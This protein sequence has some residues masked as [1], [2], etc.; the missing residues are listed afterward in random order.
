M[1]LKEQATMAVFFVYT[2]EVSGLKINLLYESKIKINT[3]GFE[4]YNL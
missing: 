1:N 3:L 2:V 4:V